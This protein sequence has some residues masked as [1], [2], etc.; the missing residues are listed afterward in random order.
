[1]STKTIYVI[2]AG[3]VI[4]TYF[5]KMVLSCL[6]ALLVSSL[7]EGNTALA[8]Q[9]VKV[10][11][12]QTSYAAPVRKSYNNSFI[13]GDDLVWIGSDATN[14]YQI[15]YRNLDTGETKQLTDTKT[16]K[17]DLWAGGDYAVYFADRREVI[18][19]NLRT[20]ES[21]SIINHTTVE[22][23]TT[24][25]RYAAYMNKTD[26]YIYVY[27][28]E[29]KQTKQLVKG[30]YPQ[31]A[32]G[33]IIMQDGKG[34][35]LLYDC[36]SGTTRTMKEPVDGYIINFKFNGKVVVW[37]QQVN[38]HTV[39]VRM[40][41]VDE[42]NAVPTVLA[43]KKMDKNTSWPTMLAIS[44][45][46]IVWR[47][48]S[49]D[50]GKSEIAA[51]ELT[52]GESIII[53][54]ETTESKLVGIYN[55]QVALQGNDGNI[56]LSS[57]QVSGTPTAKKETLASAVPDVKQR[58]QAVEFDT[59]FY[60]EGLTYKELIQSKSQV[61]GHPVSSDKSVSLVV[62]PY[63]FQDTLGKI[64]LAPGEDK[65]LELTKAM[66]SGQMMVS[67]PWNIDFPDK[68]VLEIQLNMS[69]ME[70][71]VPH[72][73]RDKLGIFRL[74]SDTW[75]YMGGLLGDNSNVIHT[76][77]EKPGIY[78][79]FLH[80]FSDGPLR[81][82]WV[83]KRIKQTI[84]EDPIRVFLD[85]E[86]LK[87]NEQPALHEN[88]TTVEFRTIFEKLGL[89]IQ[90]DENARRVT[91]QKEGQSLSL[92]LGSLS[93]SINEQSIDMPVAPY[94][95][96]GYTFVPLRFVGEA[97]GR[98]VVWDANLKAVY[99]YDAS[100]EGKLFYEDGKLKY[101]GQL[102]GGKM[103]GKGKLYRNDGSLWYDAEFQNDEV[104]GW[105][106]MYFEGFL[107]GE[108][109]T[110]E[111]I[112]GQFTRGLPNG[113]I[114]KYDD[115]GFLKY[116]GQEVFGSLTGKGKLY[117]QGRPVYEGGMKDGYFS[118]HG[119]YYVGGKLK[120]EGGFVQS[121][122]DGNGKEYD[123]NGLLQR[124]GEY[125]KGNRNGNGIDYYPSGAKSYVGP[126]V[127]GTRSG[128]GKQYYEN[129]NLR[130]EGLYEHHYIVKGTYYYDNGERYEGDFINGF[131]DGQGTLYDKNGTV[132]FQGKFK[133]GK[134]EA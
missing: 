86:E 107:F 129:G 79:I 71:R 96:K 76:A 48:A 132:K 37:T 99:L 57:L 74:E 103:N 119:K 66:Q 23:L 109:R 58:P 123:A 43:Q 100:T 46:L 70:S 93:A 2:G 15:F 5:K 1:M 89:T 60:K 29:S 126:F 62:P 17:T 61:E 64:R 8:D 21:E 88:Y 105:G 65:N 125:K 34:S 104:T 56:L 108:D 16:N 26:S 18:L 106:T 68:T 19:L 95:N 28:L 120:Y 40:M 13:S 73:L 116:E 6:M 117:I 94:S 11:D 45:N 98:K 38:E 3:E 80:D 44:S 54:N 10:T 83:N 131:P 130:A 33:K 112:T 32:D 134:P 27:D 22:N 87:F 85:G 72:N 114:R 24:D 97:T 25:G 81:E 102:K 110:G 111:I 78:A 55:D 7:G 14:L 49:E 91:G 63:S 124:E 53:A 69:Y 128:A 115:S 50:G 30:R 51:G 41:N 84:A 133:Q 90:W 35:L 20:G 127:N 67:L 47:Q 59:R 9:T 36:A 82:Y 77:I 101:E 52:Y 42:L 4:K 31:V 113:V 75:I 12:T 122:E 121:M 92:Q 39:Q 118:G